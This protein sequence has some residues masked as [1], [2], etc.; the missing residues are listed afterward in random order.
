[1]AATGPCLGMIFEAHPLSL[2][3][4]FSPEILLLRLPGLSAEIFS[5]Q[6]SRKPMLHEHADS[7]KADVAYMPAHVLFNLW[8]L[9]KSNRALYRRLGSRYAHC[10]AGVMARTFFLR[11]VASFRQFLQAG[12]LVQSGLASEGISHLHAHSC[13]VSASVAM[14]AS[15]LT[16]LP[17]SFTA[18][19]RDIH[20]SPPDQL[21]LKIRKASFVVT[22]TRSNAR[23]LSWLAR[24]HR[25]APPIHTIYRGIDTS[26]FAFEPPAVPWS[27]YRILSVGELIPKNGYDDLIRALHILRLDGLD[28]QFVHIGDG[29]CSAQLRRMA[30][31][32]DLHGM[33]AFLGP[34]PREEVLAHYRKSH[35]FVLACKTAMKADHDRI[36]N[37]LVEAMA[38]GLPVVATNVSSIRELVEHGQTGLLADPENPREIASAIWKILLNPAGS[39]ARAEMAGEKVRRDFDS[40]VSAMR[41]YE[42]F[43]RALY[44]SEKERG[45]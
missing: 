32:A 25:N 38:C 41:L 13:Q 23:F 15:E 28:F 1:M 21:A 30:E 27:P 12:H 3:S 22:C 17:F 40:R 16:G 37:E 39:R 33:A 42:L 31:E 36:P 35:C 45:K 24:I 9:F 43:N 6:K 11:R 10:L 14:Y 34:L 44:G 8:R 18:Q 26:D 19:A 7:I 4:S 29:P 5:L 2:E 20:A